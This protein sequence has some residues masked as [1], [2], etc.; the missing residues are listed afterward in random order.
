MVTH[1]YCDTCG[2]MLEAIYD[3]GNT[4]FCCG[5][6]M[7]NLQ[8]AST[9]GAREKHVPVYTKKGNILTVNVGEFPHPMEVHHHIEWIAVCTNY[10]YYR[11]AL[12]PGDTPTATFHLDENEKPLNIYAYCNLHGLWIAA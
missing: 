3:S 12:N 9:D 6:P 2:N 7:K 8:P 10:G 5:S 11:I 4:P 1:F